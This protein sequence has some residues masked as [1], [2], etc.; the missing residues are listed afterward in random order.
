MAAETTNPIA[1]RATLTSEQ[2]NKL[3]RH[4]QAVDLHQFQAQRAILDLIAKRDAYYAEI[5]AQ[6][7]LPPA[8]KSYRFNED[9]FEVDVLL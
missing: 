5:A 1:T 7:G 4:I 2:F 8:V 6:Y 9:T 3:I